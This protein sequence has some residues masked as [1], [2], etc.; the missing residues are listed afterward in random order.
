MKTKLVLLSV[1]LVASFLQSQKLCRKTKDGV[2]MFSYSGR[3][4][5]GSV[6]VEKIIS[7]N[8]LNDNSVL[9]N[10]IVSGAING[11]HVAAGSLTGLHINDGSLTGADI[12]HGSLSGAHLANRSITADKLFI[13]LERKILP[14]TT[15]Y[16]Q[17]ADFLRPSSYYVPFA[18]SFGVSSPLLASSTPLF[19]CKNLMWRIILLVRPGGGE[20]RYFELKNLDGSP[21]DP[22]G[23][24][25]ER[26]MA[27]KLE[28]NEFQKQRVWYNI[29]WG[30]Y[31]PWITVYHNSSAN[32]TPS[33]AYWYIVCTR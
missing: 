8:H 18:A 32:P 19:Y 14:Y 3:C 7:G 12:L 22:D 2:L 9:S 21:L 4:P 13:D 6:A 26:D 11:D 25:P 24:G 33:F 30:E 20:Y 5:K 29:D 31:I 17:S 15:Y 1:F 10:H 16:G 28:N 27:I 23:P